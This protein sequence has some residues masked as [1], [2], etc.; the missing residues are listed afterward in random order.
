MSATSMSLISS[1]IDEFKGTFSPQDDRS[2]I[3]IDSVRLT[4]S[5]FFESFSYLN[6]LIDYQFTN[7]IIVFNIIA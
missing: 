2:H 3:C 1:E 5:T 7:S 6:F 4:S